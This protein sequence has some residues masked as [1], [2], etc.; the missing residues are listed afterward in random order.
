MTSRILTPSQQAGLL[1]VGDVII[2]GDRQFP[3]FSR[4]RCADHVDR[5]LAYMNDADLQPLQVLLGLFRYCP[6]LVLRG[7]MALTDQHQAFPD[8]I[9][10]VLRMINIG[11]KGMVVTLYYSDLGE[12]TSIYELIHWDAKIVDHGLAATDDAVAVMDHGAI[13][14][15]SAV[16]NN[17]SAPKEES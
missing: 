10:A 3:S 14:V 17:G 5:M 8:A 15:D 12:G 1:R 7:L 13:A 4:S 9:G 16:V 6:K 2:P 11:I